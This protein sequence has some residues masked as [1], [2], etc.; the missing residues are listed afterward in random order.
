[1]KFLKGL[2]YMISSIT[3]KEIFLSSRLTKP[4]MIGLVLSCTFFPMR[5]TAWN[6]IEE[7]SSFIS[8]CKILQIKALQSSP[9]VSLMLLNHRFSHLV[10]C[11][12]WVFLSVSSFNFFSSLRILSLRAFML[13]VLASETFLT[14][15][16][17][18]STSS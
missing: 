6:F 17:S 16:F 13:L 15:T 4:T 10:Y 7:A 8:F 18:D 3:T 9:S 2:R 14:V 12:S 11:S 5:W 1:M